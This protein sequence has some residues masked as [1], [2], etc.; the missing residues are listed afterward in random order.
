MKI[1][2]I[3]IIDWMKVIAVI[4]AATGLFMTANQQRK[5]NS[6]KR[7]EVI[8]DALWKIQDDKEVREI[9]YR[10]EYH[11]FTYDQNF[12]GSDNE[13]YLD[14]LISLLDIIAKQYFSG[15]LSKKDVALVSYEYLIIYQNEDVQKYFAFLDS[16]FENR[17]VKHPPFESFRK[18]G[19][20]IEDNH[21]EY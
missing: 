10:L 2:D 9:Y 7:V 13:K 21:F 18:L 12:H 4:V 1:L 16:W 5:A 8:S 14:K 17:G 11:E 19:K 15:H 6:Q 20:V 3:D